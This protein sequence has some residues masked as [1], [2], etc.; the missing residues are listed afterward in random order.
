MHHIFW[1]TLDAFV[2]FVKSFSILLITTF[3]PTS[4]FGVPTLYKMFSFKS[5]VITILA[6]RPASRGT[7]T[8]FAQRPTIRPHRMKCLIYA[9][10]VLNSFFILQD[11]RQ[12]ET[13]TLERAWLIVRKRFS[14]RTW[15][16]KQTYFLSSP[17]SKSYICRHMGRGKNWIDLNS[18]LLVTVISLIIHYL[19][20]R[21]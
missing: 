17:M 2:S 11:G 21:K 9:C 5:S 20:L 16:T 12:Q 1:K 14:N 4:P 18:S 15:F 6:N 8:H 3:C 7:R 13:K 10:F 19:F